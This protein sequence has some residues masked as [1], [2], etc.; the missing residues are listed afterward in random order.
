MK[1]LFV[2]R[3]VD[4]SVGATFKCISNIAD[5]LVAC[6][7]SADIVG[8]AS[9]PFE[10]SEEISRNLS[11]TRIRLGRCMSASSLSSYLRIHP[12]EALS[13]CVDKVFSKVAKSRDG[14][15]DQKMV[16]KLQNYVESVACEYDA[17]IAVS[18]AIE[19][20]VAVATSTGPLVR[21]LYQVDPYSTNVRFGDACVNQR[22]LF[23][24][25]LYSR[26]DWVCTT[27]II[28]REN[29]AF[30]FNMSNVRDVEFPKIMPKETCINERKAEQEYHL[31]FSGY[32]SK[33]VRDP[34]F[35]L[36]FADYA[37]SCFPDFQFYLYSFGEIS[38]YIE[39]SKDRANVHWMDPVAEDEIQKIQANADCLVNI[40]NNKPNQIPSKLLDYISHGKPILNLC[41]TSSCPTIECLRGYPLALSVVESDDSRVFADILSFLQK[42]KGCR[43]DYSQILEKYGDYTPE[44]VA[45]V[46][47]E[48][49]CETMDLGQI[50][51]G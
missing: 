21:V 36:R 44:A 6:G 43:L 14:V 1:I 48:C 3:D 29:Q 45:K 33:E 18:A 37:S 49:V 20:A 42:T 10:A 7:D 12:I 28:Y 34:A 39:M 8:F 17:V 25:S 9:T 24:K 50:K 16:R 5:A 11:I 26:F 51:E 15:P 32:L 30:G 35:F 41:K 46:L 27:P 19:A 23:E 40:G 38:G 4:S 47:R 2:A 13:L 22:V 31:V